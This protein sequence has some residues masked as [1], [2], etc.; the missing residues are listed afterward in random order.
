M[1]KLFDDDYIE[2]IIEYNLNFNIPAKETIEKLIQEG[3]EV[4]NIIIDEY[5][6]NFEP[7]R[8]Y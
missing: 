1:T 7:S 3:I 6:N 8:S 4:S 5:I 2:E